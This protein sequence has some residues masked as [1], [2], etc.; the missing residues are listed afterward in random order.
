ML[1]AD[2][3]G[4][5]PFG[6]VSRHAQRTSAECDVTFLWW[7]EILYVVRAARV[8]KNGVPKLA[9]SQPVASQ[10]VGPLPVLD[11]LHR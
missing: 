2:I 9:G 10:Q 1:L 8:V 4:H 5:S 6:R 11:Y 7:N 3:R